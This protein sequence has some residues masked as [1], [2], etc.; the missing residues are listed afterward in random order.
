MSVVPLQRPTDTSDRQRAMGAR[1]LQAQ[2]G[3][4]RHYKEGRRRVRRLDAFHHLH[5]G[6]PTLLEGSRRKWKFRFRTSRI[7]HI[8]HPHVNHFF[9]SR[10]VGLLGTE[11]RHRT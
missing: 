6:A 9:V 1:S 5:S 8:L 10:E 4:P 7:P 11:R 3:H 2:M